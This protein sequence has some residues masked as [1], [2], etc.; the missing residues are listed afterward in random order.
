MLLARASSEL[1]RAAFPDVIAGLGLAD[2]DDPKPS[3][4]GRTTIARRAVAQPPTDQKPEP[5][6]PARPETSPP[7]IS[8]PQM[9]RLQIM[10]R[11]KGITDR[12][13]RL[14]YTAGIVGRE[15]ASANDLTSD[16]ASHVI[17]A[18]ADWHPEAGADAL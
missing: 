14:K 13:M 10:F 4:G 17:T 3:G 6:P 15:L 9:K 8:R 5:E 1:C 16:E 18:L 11:E 7:P 2:D 12:D